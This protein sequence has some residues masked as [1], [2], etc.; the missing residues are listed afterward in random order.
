LQG[1]GGLSDDPWETLFEMATCDRPAGANDLIPFWI[2][3]TPGGAKV[4]RRVPMLP[5]SKEVERLRQLKRSLAVYRLVMGQPRQEDLLAHLG[6]FV[7]ESGD[8]SPDLP[9]LSLAP[10]DVITE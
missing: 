9:V 5:Y 1:R 7:D 3:E 2:Y 4:E 8:P 6:R 10:P